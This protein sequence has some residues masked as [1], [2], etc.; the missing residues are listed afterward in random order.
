[1]WLNLGMCRLLQLTLLLLPL[2]LLLC[3][4]LSAVSGGYTRRLRL[5]EDFNMLMPAL[6]RSEAVAGYFRCVD[7]WIKHLDRFVP[8]VHCTLCHTSTL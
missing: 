2:P 6:Q 4:Q 1:M 5:L 8:Q 3:L 7:I